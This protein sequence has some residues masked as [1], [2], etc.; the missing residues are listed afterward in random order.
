MDFEFEFDTTYQAKIEGYTYIVVPDGNHW[1][2]QFRKRGE[3]T[4][5]TDARH[6]SKKAAFEHVRILAIHTPEEESL[7]TVAII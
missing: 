6:E 4:H 5:Q 2:V 1:R 7:E 3:R